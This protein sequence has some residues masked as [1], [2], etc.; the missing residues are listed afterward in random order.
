MKQKVSGRE[1]ASWLLGVGVGA[2]WAWA[3]TLHLG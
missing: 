1:L 2:A 3:L